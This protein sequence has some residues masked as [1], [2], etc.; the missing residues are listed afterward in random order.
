MTVAER[1]ELWLVRQ[2]PLPPGINNTAA[3]LKICF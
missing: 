3:R 1:M 2:E